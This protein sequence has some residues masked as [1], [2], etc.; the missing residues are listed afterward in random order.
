MLATQAQSVP[1]THVKDM[2]LKHWTALGLAKV[3]RDQITVIYDDEQ[4][5]QFIKETQGFTISQ[6]KTNIKAD[7]VQLLIKMGVVLPDGIKAT[8]ANYQ[9]YLESMLI[10]HPWLRHADP[11]KCLLKILWFLKTDWEKKPDP[12]AESSG[13]ED[14]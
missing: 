14:I 12:I 4:L 7:T 9:Q 3:D 8:V 5:Q 6:F 2:K 10:Q 13:D 1:L 11:A